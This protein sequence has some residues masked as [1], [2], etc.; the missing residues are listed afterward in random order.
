MN[1]WIVNHYADAPDRQSTRTYDL[2]RKLVERGH[3]VTIFA[4]GFSHYSF[5]E[6]RV[7]ANQNSV[8]E[9]SCG[10]RFI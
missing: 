9:D 8:V 3:R 7:P 2:A 5:K 6:E 10:V 4:A 1:I